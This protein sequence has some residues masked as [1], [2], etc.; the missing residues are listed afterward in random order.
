MIHLGV[1]IHHVA[2]GRCRHILYKIKK[3]IKEE[4][5]WMPDAITF[6]IFLNT[7]KSFSAKYLFNDSGDDNL[8][9]FNGNELDQI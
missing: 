4:V 8:K 1:H 9:L 3:L 5:N 6:A 7:S 2:D